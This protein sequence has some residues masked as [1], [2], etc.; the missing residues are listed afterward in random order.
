MAQQLEANDSTPL[1]SPDILHPTMGQE[2]EERDHGTNSISLS[3]SI[4]IEPNPDLFTLSSSTSSGSSI[5]MQQVDRDDE[6]MP[7]LPFASQNSAMEQQQHEGREPNAHFNSPRVEHETQPSSSDVMD[8]GTEQQYELLPSLPPSSGEPSPSHQ[9]S[10]ED[11]SVSDI[12][13]HQVEREQQ[14][15]HQPFSLSVPLQ[16]SIM[17]RRK[18]RAESASAARGSTS[19]R[20]LQNVTPERVRRI[21]ST[22]G[23]DDDLSE[24]LFKLV[25][26]TAPFYNPESYPAPSAAGESNPQ[27]EA[28]RQ[29]LGGLLFSPQP[30]TATAT[31]NGPSAGNTNDN[32]TGNLLFDANAAETLGSR[33]IEP[34]SDSPPLLWSTAA[35][36]EP[37]DP[38]AKDP[39]YYTVAE[40]VNTII[41]KKIQV[42]SVTEEDWQIEAV[43][44]GILNHLMNNPPDGD[45]VAEGGLHE[46]VRTEDQATEQ[47]K[48]KED[49]SKP[50]STVKGDSSKVGP[51]EKKAPEDV[52]AKE[53]TSE[54]DLR[55][56]EAQGPSGWLKREDE[57]DM[58]EEEIDDECARWDAMVRKA[59]EEKE[60]ETTSEGDGRSA[61]HLQSLDLDLGEVFG[62]VAAQIESIGLATG[63][64]ELTA[65]DTAESPDTN[66]PENS[67]ESLSQ[68]SG[69]HSPSVYSEHGKNHFH[70]RLLN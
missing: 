61:I 50:D 65:T 63:D 35:V 57:T 13:A 24:T 8:V 40:F 39:T 64:K 25:M 48:S 23:H 67:I 15:H 42:E 56:W 2:R 27:A 21:I 36:E 45:P 43:R 55:K 37:L 29:T 44:V 5:M 19:Q 33:P 1:L 58:N 32:P 46:A 22:L 69:L 7:L 16:S 3:S 49:T 6:N 11:Y 34:R 53:D 30:P 54:S 51:T 59:R 18:A 60:A 14:Q 10:V 4:I 41:E 9:D 31:E 52:Q 26:A 38:D 12:V 20:G 70:C 17:L 62:S 47:I 28:L 66:P 68:D